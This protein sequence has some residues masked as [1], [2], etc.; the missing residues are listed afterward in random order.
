MNQSKSRLTLRI[1]LKMLLKMQLKV[2]KKLLKPLLVNHQ[3][4]YK[5]LKMDTPE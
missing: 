1:M 5:E 2:L 4:S 3:D